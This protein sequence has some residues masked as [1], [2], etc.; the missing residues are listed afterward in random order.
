M[1]PQ[2][3]RSVSVFVYM[4][5]V[6]PAYRCPCWHVIVCVCMC[7]CMWDSLP[8]ALMKYDVTVALETAF[9]PWHSWGQEAWQAVTRFWVASDSLRDVEGLR[10]WVPSLS[11]MNTLGHVG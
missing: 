7:G 6:V 2:Y 11:C 5:L 8:A 9:L 4:S 10:P 1:F 3:K